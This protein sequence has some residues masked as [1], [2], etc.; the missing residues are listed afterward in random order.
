MQMVKQELFVNTI[1][2]H[3]MSNR[4]LTTEKNIEK[5]SK[6]IITYDDGK[7]NGYRR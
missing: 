4:I 5:N 6:Q 3:K 7:C 1:E 2:E